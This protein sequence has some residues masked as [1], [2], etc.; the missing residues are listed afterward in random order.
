MTT[1][2]DTLTLL[3]KVTSATVMPLSMAAWRSTWSEPIPAVMASFRLGALATRS[4]VRYAGQKGW[5]ITISAS[6]SSRSKV[7][8]GPSLSEVTTK[9]WPRPSR[10]VRSPSSPD[11]LPR[12]SPGVKSMACGVGRV[13]PPG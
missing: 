4:S 1:C 6:T 5:E 11:T 10:K 8:S 3:L 13:W 12:S 2:S 7:E 9:L